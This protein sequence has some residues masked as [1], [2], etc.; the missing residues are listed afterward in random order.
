MR[1][2]TVFNQLK[3]RASLGQLGNSS[4]GNYPYASLV[5]NGGYYPFGGVST[6]S[7][8]IT[9]TGNPNIRWETSTQ[10]DVGLDAALLKGALQ[11]TVDYFIKKTTNVLQYLPQPP[12]GGQVGS[13]AANAGSVRNQGLEVQLNYRNTIGKDW[14]FNVGGN[15]ATLRNEVLSLGGA[16][17]IVGGRI[18][19]NYYAT[20]TQVGQPIG[21]FYLLQTD[22]IFQNAQQVFTS[23]YQGPNIQPGDVKFKDIS[24]PDGT[25]DGIIDGNDRTFV[26]SPIPKLTYGLTGNAR[27]KNFDLSVFFQGVYGNMLYNQVNTDIEGF[28][29]AFNLTERAATNY[30][31]AEGSTNEFPRLSWTGA[32]NN[33]Q[34]STRFLES[35]SYLRLKNVQLGYTLGEHLL[36]PLHIASVRVYASVQNL[37]TFTKYTGLDPEQGVNNNSLGDGVRAVGIDFGNYPSARTF[38]LGVSAGF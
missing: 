27:Y 3:L 4:I 14:S 7:L 30:W 34:P 24:G 38:T 8:T 28:Y 36:N 37:L 19:N 2:V 25:P 9:T 32:T 15:L 21:S 16:P 13:P 18:D 5:G 6:Q 33:K 12:S 20:L 23:P 29:R 35:G 22:G 10:T 31:T 26:G 11:V 1:N 17:P